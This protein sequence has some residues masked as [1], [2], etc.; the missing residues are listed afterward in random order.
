MWYSFFLFS[1]THF[2]KLISPPVPVPAK[3]EQWDVVFLLLLSLFS[4]F[5]IRFILYITSTTVEVEVILC[6]KH[7]L[8]VR[9]MGMILNVF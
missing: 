2:L 8:A 3:K 9:E 6:A 1:P 7:V 4:V 5:P